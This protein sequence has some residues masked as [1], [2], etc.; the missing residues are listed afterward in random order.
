MTGSSPEIRLSLKNC[1]DYRYEWV[2]VVA[3]VFCLVAFC[4]IVASRYPKVVQAV[5]YDP[6]TQA[7]SSPPLELRARSGRTT[8]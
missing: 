4:Y 8:R 1:V 7:G 3:I 5:T 2:R 6:D